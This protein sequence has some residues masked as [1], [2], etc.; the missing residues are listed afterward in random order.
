MHLTESPLEN[1]RKKYE[2]LT[3]EGLHASQVYLSVF[4]SRFARGYVDCA[5]ICGVGTK[6]EY[7]RG[8]LVR[9]ALDAFFRDAGE[10]PEWA[11]SFL[12]PFSFPFYRQMG[13]EKISYH[14]AIEMPIGAL[15]MFARFP[16]FAPFAPEMEKPLLECYRRFAAGRNMMFDRNDLSRFPLRDKN[17]L[18]VLLEGGEIH[19]YIVWRVEDRMVVNRMI[20]DRLVVDEYGFD[21]PDALKKL[22]GFIRMFDGQVL[23]VRFTDVYMT[24]EID[25]TL[26][27]YHSVEYK[28]YPDIS[29]KILNLKT[30]LEM[31]EYPRAGGG[32]TIAEAGG[33]SW[34]VDYEG[35][36]AQVKPAK[37]G[38]DIT[39]DSPAL[40]RLLYGAEP[41]T[42][43][44]LRYM[45]GVEIGGDTEDFLRAFP[46]R[47]GGVFEHF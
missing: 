28:L 42:A 11:V 43:E 40:A 29:A 38:A 14:E 13:Y 44:R 22:L 33:E 39:C 3:D 18:Y 7:R 32:F 35:G 16:D 46:V 36:Q 20:G 30:M 9:T 31:N 5:C 19:A 34:R 21:S 24:P 37:C 26:R 4:P 25:V 27:H 6:P 45:P 47:A 2:M 1:G 15:D 17:Q 23:N 12:H 41:M 8:G 10:H